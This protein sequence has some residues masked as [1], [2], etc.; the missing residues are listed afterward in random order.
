MEEQLKQQTEL[1]RQL[2]EYFSAAPSKG[3]GIVPKPQGARSQYVTVSI[4]PMSPTLWQY[5]TPSGTW[6]T[7]E[8]E[9]LNGTVTN[10]SVYTSTQRDYSKGKS[11]AAT[12]DVPKVTFHF[13]TRECTYVVKSSCLS[14]YTKGFVS[15]LSALTDEELRQPVTI[16]LERGT[17][18]ESVALCSL[19]KSN[20]EQ[21]FKGAAVEGWAER[22]GQYIT[23][24]GDRIRRIHGTS[25][26]F[27]DEG[28]P[29]QVRHI[30][31]DENLPF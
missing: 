13:E 9:A 21:V 18:Y 28:T 11:S 8:A 5:K 10:Y 14:A 6:E 23:K 25:E 16:A 26:P 19:W 31:E 27:K 7:F 20:G 29:E 1:L 30:D 17:E 2:L 24:L 12:V 15:R 3:R 4:Y 22:Y